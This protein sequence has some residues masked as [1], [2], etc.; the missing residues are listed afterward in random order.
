[1]VDR[2]AVAAAVEEGKLIEVSCDETSK[3]PQ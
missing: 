1:L 2:T 3:I